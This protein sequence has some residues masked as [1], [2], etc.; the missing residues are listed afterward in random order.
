LNVVLLLLGTFVYIA[1]G[2][3]SRLADMQVA[4]REFSTSDFSCGLSSDTL[5]GEVARALAGSQ[6]DQPRISRGSIPRGNNDSR[7]WISF[8]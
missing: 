7:F 4:R 8:D 6:R 2:T 5:I 1:A 3:S